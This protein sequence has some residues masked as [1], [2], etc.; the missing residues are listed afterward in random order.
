MAQ[1]SPT[2]SAVVI[3]GAGQ[4]GFQT[5]L[6]LR[7]NDY[8]GSVTIVGD[9]AELPY[10]RP[11]LSK[12][13]LAG[14]AADAESATLT[15]RPRS[16]YQRHGLHLIQD[17]AVAIDRARSVIGLG[18]GREIRYGHLVLATGARARTVP[19]PGAELPN[20][21]TL[22][23]R[24]D[25]DTLR[26][27][28]A[29]GRRVVIIGGGLIG[30]E[31]TAAARTAGAEVAVVE[32]LDRIMARAAAPEISDYVTAMH[33]DRGTRVLLG[34]SMVAVQPGTGESCVVELTGGQSLPA[35]T[36]VVGIG[37]APNT[38][39]ASQADLEVDDGIVV[40]ARLLTS[41]PAISAIGDCAAHPNLHA[42]HRTRLESV[43]NAVDHA[44]H[45]ADRITGGSP[46]PYAKVPWFWTRQFNMRIQT[47]GIARP[48]DI[49]VVHGDPSGGRFSVFRF[50]R[51]RLVAVESVNRTADHV[52][53]RRL[54][55]NGRLLDPD[56]AVQPIG[57]DVIAQPGFDLKAFVSRVSE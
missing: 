8:R 35:D 23:T 5:A 26:A 55:A 57:P 22:R 47:A 41:D 45:V 40:D 53:A 32:M 19:V 13:Y 3:I 31:V 2:P 34:R 12:G 49:R 25:A 21:L 7:E 51:D 33:R 24:A 37:V 20:V 54:L 1:T 15:L 16:F 50:H 56:I 42:G 27:R 46:G 29:P 30:M 17:F 39:L 44:R 9:E 14:E 43:Q 52:A 6:S 36:V 28:L 18:S 11:P 10:Q 38:E 4:A 48:D